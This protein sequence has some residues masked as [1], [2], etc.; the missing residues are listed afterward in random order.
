MTDVDVNKVAARLGEDLESNLYRRVRLLKGVAV[1]HEL[2]A[3]PGDDGELET[4]I[5][6]IRDYSVGP[7]YWSTE[8][9]RFA[10]EELLRALF[11]QPYQGRIQTPDAFWE[12]EP[13][14]MIAAALMRLEGDGLIRPKAASALIGRPVA[15]IHQ[16]IHR[17]ALPSIRVWDERWK[18]Y[19]RL[20]RRD[21]VLA[22][23]GGTDEEAA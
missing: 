8:L 10:I 15:A 7:W 11:E 1:E 17:G 2:M 5:G 20:V 4:A 9:V 22:L 18:R 19:G 14:R 16:A 13:G 21:D 12:S 23:A 3:E 6:V